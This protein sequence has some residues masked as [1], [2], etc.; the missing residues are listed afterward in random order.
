MMQSGA[1]GVINRLISGVNV[2][3]IT[4][5]AT[6]M[7]LVFVNASYQ[8]NVISPL[9]YHAVHMVS[10]ACLGLLIVWF[11]ISQVDKITLF[12]ILLICGTAVLF[13]LNEILF[14][15]TT[16]EAR[17]VFVRFALYCLPLVVVA[18]QIE[19]VEVLYRMLRK[20]TVVAVLVVVLL[21]LFR[22]SVT[23]RIQQQTYSMG[24]GYAL[25]PFALIAFNEFMREGL[26]LSVKIMFGLYGLIISSGIVILGSRGP[27][28]CIGCY[29]V[30]TILRWIVHG[31]RPLLT[32]IILLL[33]AT[34]L[35]SYRVVL[36]F[37]VQ[38]LSMGGFSRTGYLLEQ[39]LQTGEIHLSGRDELQA[40]LFDE[41]LD[42][43]FAIRGIAADR[44]FAG[45]NAHNLLLEVAFCFGLLALALLVV[46][47]LVYFV[48][49]LK[50]PIG[51][52]GDLIVSFFSASVPSLMYSGSLWDN[53]IFW[54]GTAITFFALCSRQGFGG[55]SS[56]C[57]APACE[58][59][60]L[61][62]ARIDKDLK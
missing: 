57:V 12:G 36:G 51:R 49:C 46:F 27:L 38:V 37:A 20:C 24:L 15:E 54:I 16:D 18:S 31:R 56:A 53:M 32:V 5:S 40:P 7:L 35:L 60:P 3:E 39:F 26:S 29:F 17:R 55:R 43:P 45:M 19:S 11:C 28:V 42:D 47:L 33:L 59:Y 44:V 52:Y 22:F 48:R 61:E 50:V 1:Q 23:A 34:M 9:F 58:I 30:L 8:F 41:V 2:A 14:P 25:L 10:L 6:L 62:G 21:L 4:V 13:L